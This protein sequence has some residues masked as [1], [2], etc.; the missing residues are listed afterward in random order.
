MAFLSYD[1]TYGQHYA[2][3]LFADEQQ[4]SSRGTAVGK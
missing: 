3:F 2:F 1:V 4:M